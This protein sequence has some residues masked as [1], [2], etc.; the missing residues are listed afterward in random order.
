MVGMYIRD[1]C[2]DPVDHHLCKTNETLKKGNAMTIKTRPGSSQHRE[3]YDRAF[4]AR[5]RIEPTNHTSFTISSY[6]KE[7][8]ELGVSVVEYMVWY[9]DIEI[10]DKGIFWELPEVSDTPEIR[11]EIRAWWR[12]KAYRDG[13][14]KREIKKLEISGEKV[15]GV[16]LNEAKILSDEIIKSTGMANLNNKK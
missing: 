4:G 10:D 13:S 6:S 1:I 12:W 11:E 8:P 9:S 3:G 2:G 5:D 14:T 16:F 15:G 7:K